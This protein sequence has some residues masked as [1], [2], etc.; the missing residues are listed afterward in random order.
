MPTRI[1]EQVTATSYHA[2]TEWL[3]GP[4]RD[5]CMG[6]R[7][8][9]HCWQVV[10]A[11]EWARQGAWAKDHFRWAY[12]ADVAERHAHHGG[13]PVVIAPGVRTRHCHGPH[14]L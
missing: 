8:S 13:C 4:W 6:L 12:Q 14:L 7:R 11:E 9:D 2:H 1:G 3:L 5:G 10:V